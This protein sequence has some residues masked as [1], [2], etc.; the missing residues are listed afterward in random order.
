MCAA[1]SF[2]RVTGREGAGPRGIDAISLDVGGVLLVPD[3]GMLS[4]AL[5]LAGVDH[6]RSQFHE[7]HYRAMAEVDRRQSRPEEFAD[8]THGF[9]RA[10]GVA[11]DQVEAGAAALEPVLASPVWCQRV[12]GAVAA[13]RRLAA[14]GLRLAVT[15]N[16]DG[17]VAEVMRRHE[18]A[19][20]GDG[21]GVRLEH[22]SDSTVVGVAKPDAAI[23]LATAAALGL[24][25]ERICHVGDAGTFDAD[26][27]RAVG[28]LAVHV[29][30]L[31]LCGRDVDHHHLTSLADLADRLLASPG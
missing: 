2:D 30:P 6:D 27:A 12:P 22:V 19:Q 9:L 8:Y 29:D 15:S 5:R 20:V 18:V 28:M 17:S 1:V 16:S 10:V 11:P 14:A 31:G 13:A 26:G 23:F 7:G 21:P 4:H 24:A 25:P 3:H